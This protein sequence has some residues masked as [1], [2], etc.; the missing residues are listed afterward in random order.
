MPVSTKPQQPD[1]EFAKRYCKTSR[2]AFYMMNDPDETFVTVDPSR[3]VTLEVNPQQISMREPVATA[4]QFTQGGG[5][6]RESRGG[7]VKP[8]NI[9]GTTG[10]TPL[11]QGKSLHTDLPKWWSHGQQVR[12][13]LVPRD[14][15]AVDEMLGARSGFY[16]FHRLR[17]L[18]RLYAYELRQGN[19]KVTLHYVDT[20]NDEYWR[21]EPQEFVMQRS[22]RKAMSFD[23]SISFQIIEESTFGSLGQAFT[24]FPLFEDFGTNVGVSQTL[25]GPR[26]GSGVT[27]TIKNFADRTTAGLNYLKHCSGVVQAKFQ[28]LL[29]KVNAVVGYVENIHSTALIVAETWH[30]LLAQTDNALAGMFNTISLYAPDNIEREINEWCLETQWLNDHLRAYVSSIETQSKQIINRVNG[31]FRSGRL[32]TGATTD[33]LTDGSD[34]S[35]SPDTNPFIGT[36]GLGLVTDLQKLS[37]VRQLKA[38]MVFQGDTIHTLALRLLGDVQ[39]FVDLIL[40]NNLA[41]PYIVADGAEKPA[42]TIAW[43]E[44]INIPADAVGNMVDDGDAPL[45]PTF[46]S[47]VTRTSIPTELVDEELTTPWR[48]N[49]WVGYTVTLTRGG[50]D[51]VRVVVGNTDNTLTVNYPWDPTPQEGDAYSLTLVLFDRHRPLTPEARAYGTDLLL[52]FTST[53]GNNQNP[54]ADIVIDS[55]RGLA[56]VR[57]VDNLIQSLM[58]RLNTEQKRHPFHPGFGVQAPVGQAWNDDIRFL[59]TFFIRKS[60]LSDPRVSAVRNARMEMRGDTVSFIADVQPINV[61]NTRQIAVAVR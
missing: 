19:T 47:L 31:A 14:V 22:S 40:L 50:T 37:S 27:Q 58:L 41:P 46:S 59:Y 43:G 10:Y 9:S 61:R 26:V 60:L 45:A 33:L 56:V 6:I 48:D 52:N 38:A 8:V 29:N 36:S 57:G 54:R 7:L 23:Y 49:Q 15:N 2:Y 4:I 21:I 32:K 16:A 44:Y 39:R 25:N 17:H 34:S 55:S 20:K 28:H 12:G 11:P 35:G 18:F 53:T 3:Y 5:K 42:N 1:I 51:Y 13:S 24:G 30:T